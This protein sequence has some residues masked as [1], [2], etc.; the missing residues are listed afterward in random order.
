MQINA[1]F[2]IIIS[3]VLNKT[4]GNFPGVMI[5]MMFCVSTDFLLP[6]GN[7]TGLAQ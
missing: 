5:F 1:H 7:F 3:S 2:I 4:P 6:G